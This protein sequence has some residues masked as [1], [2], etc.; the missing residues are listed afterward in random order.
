MENIKRRTIPILIDVE[1]LIQ[2]PVLGEITD[3]MLQTHIQ[4]FV[5]SVFVNVPL[6][7]EEGDFFNL[8]NPQVFITKEQLNL[9]AFEKIPTDDASI[10]ADFER[11]GTDIK[12]LAYEKRCRELENE[13]CD[14]SDAQGIAG[15]EGLDPDFPSPDSSI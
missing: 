9:F 10:L 1:N 15:E 12:Y 8:I 14:R 11:D 13:G 3:D 7:E 4:S 6:V 5:D 2:S